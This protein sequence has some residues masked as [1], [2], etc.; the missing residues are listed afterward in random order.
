MLLYSIGLIFFKCLIKKKY[1]LS[2]NL[3][4]VP[5]K[6]KSLTILDLRLYIMYQRNKGEKQQ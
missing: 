6:I 2:F 1:R 4:Q 5:K 3:H